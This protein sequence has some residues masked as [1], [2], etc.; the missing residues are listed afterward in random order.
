MAFKRSVFG[1][2]V[3]DGIGYTE[4][5]KEQRKK[6]F[7][8]PKKR[9]ITYHNP[10]HIYNFMFHYYREYTRV[11]TYLTRKKLSLSLNQ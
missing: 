4:K 6:G 3:K 10:F 8:A 5:V 9:K 7:R 11:P 1:K 2:Y